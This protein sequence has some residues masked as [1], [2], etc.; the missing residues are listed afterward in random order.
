MTIEMAETVVNLGYI[1][2]KYQ[3]IVHA[4]ATRFTVVVTHRR[5][6]KTYLSCAQ[7]VDAA[8][9]TTKPDAK[10]AYLAPFLKQA[11]Q[12]AWDYLRQFSGPVGASVNESELTIK[13]PNN[14]KITLF[15][16]DNAEALRGGYFDGIVIDEVADL[17]PDVWGSIL[18]P[19][20]SDRKGWAFF[21][22]TP[23]GI[24]LFHDLYEWASNGFPVGDERVL[25][26]EW[27]ALMFRVDETG[28]IDEK[29][30]ASSKAT[31]SAAQ[32]RQEWLCDFSAASDNILIGI[33]LV[34]QACQREP[35]ERLVTGSP[36][37]L[38]VD[39]A[40]FGDD[41]SV[42]IR[43]QGLVASPPIVLANMN[44]MD[45]A[46]R[47]A[48]DIN[49]WQPD[50]VFI[51]AGRGEGVIDRLRQL[52]FDVIEINFGGKPI[53]DSYA[54]KRTEMWDGMAKW[55]LAGGVIP[56][57]PE[58]KTDLAVPTYS[59]NAAGKMILESK[60][61]IKKRGLRSTDV[62]DALALTFAMP[63]SPRAASTSYAR[64]RHNNGDGYSPFAE[65]YSSAGRQ[66]GWSAARRD[67]WSG[68]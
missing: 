19:A 29:E 38:G 4:K 17:R 49:T 21:I 56:N 18:R 36:K 15:G 32:Y 54:N 46:G 9:R 12:S 24:N 31:Q 40:R 59:F 20:L 53:V 66:L 45:L 62:G 28:I 68:N 63:V 8:L 34:S 6:G 10:F 58:L 60:D 55:L 11:K 5:F 48:A 2:H 50:A 37:I 25:D 51:D 14:A 47:V 7:L 23:K 61:D 1:P 44:N 35:L 43:R 30:L 3:A 13:F 41:R 16:G 39:V 33:D 57:L 22:G 27:T 26:P 65:M 67:A 64:S 52:H 42:I